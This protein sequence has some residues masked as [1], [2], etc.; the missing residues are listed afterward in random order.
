[1][2]FFSKKNANQ[3][4]SNKSKVIMLPN[5]AQYHR[6]RGIA[7]M[8]NNQNEEAL[9][10]FKKA[11]E[12]DPDDV[13]TL[14]A[15]AML[16]TDI[17]R[18]EEALIMCNVVLDR[19]DE[20]KSQIY[21]LMATNFVGT[22]QFDAAYRVLE[23]L[24]TTAHNKHVCADAKKMQREIEQYCEGVVRDQRFFDFD[25][26]LLFLKVSDHVRAEQLLEGLGEQFPDHVDVL[27]Q[28]VY[29]YISTDRIDL[30]K[31]MIDRIVR[32]D[33]ENVL[34]SCSQ[35]VIHLR[36]LLHRN[37]EIDEETLQRMRGDL[38]HKHP[39]NELEYHAMASVFAIAQDDH[40]V[41]HMIKPILKNEQSRMLGQA[42][43]IAAIAS[44]NLGMYDHAR[45]YWR[46][47]RDE[48]DYDEWVS[49]YEQLASHWIEHSEKLQPIHR[50]TLRYE[51]DT[52]SV[53][54]VEWLHSV[55]RLYAQQQ[56]RDIVHGQPL[57]WMML[58][59]E[60]F[61]APQ[62]GP[63]LVE[64]YALYYNERIVQ[65]FD[66]LM[67][68]ER[69][70]ILMR[71]HIFFL[72]HNV[73]ELHTSEKKWFHFARA[74]QWPLTGNRFWDE[75]L[76]DLY[77]TMKRQ[78]TW[79]IFLFMNMLSFVCTCGPRISEDGL[80]KRNMRA[81]KAVVHYYAGC[82][83][84]FPMQSNVFDDHP[85]TFSSSYEQMLISYY[86]TT[87]K[88][89]QSINAV[90]EAAQSMGNMESMHSIGSHKEDFFDH[91]TQFWYNM[92]DDDDEDS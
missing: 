32:I 63:W 21:I 83:G 46:K 27:N 65:K 64:Y 41:L 78:K 6:Q 56:A 53:E 33:P 50:I 40:H 80:M 81:W 9:L 3:K 72:K 68:D 11:L 29:V 89:F 16:L 66:A 57:F 28:L 52:L 44:F 58:D 48:T 31:E 45:L 13:E 51:S 74:V 22:L 47:L 90:A 77:D 15:I 85:N 59:M 73:L 91:A 86:K 69:N 75:L 17:E 19:L 23:L 30:A 92:N 55:H 88:S 42:Y 34:A 20:D 10:C 71:Q 79:N 37:N 25:R 70:P 18:A 36:T 7:M 87:K 67:R 2:K 61:W 60:Q 8:G 82:Y 35:W 5:D 49:M 38:L 4:K 62:S 1:M 43:H 39:K 24:R 76:C 12:L 26:A 84:M 14:I 54:L